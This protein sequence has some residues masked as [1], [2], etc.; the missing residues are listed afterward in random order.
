MIP[1]TFP[2]QLVSGER[3]MTVF[4]ITDTTGLVEWID[5]IPVKEVTA[6]ASLRGTYNAGSA[7]AVAVLASASGLHAGRDYIRVYVDATKSVPWTTNNDGY[8]PVEAVSGV[9]TGGGALIPSYWNYNDKSTV[10][11]IILDDRFIG[12]AAT[13]YGMVRSISS[14]SSGKYYIEVLRNVDFWMIG[15]ASASETLTGRYPGDVGTQSVGLY[16]DQSYENGVGVQVNT[17]VAFTGRVGM[18]INADDREYAFYDGV[19]IHPFRPLPFAGD[20][21]LVGGPGSTGALG[22]GMYLNAGQDAFG[23]TVPS[24]Y[25]AG[26]GTFG[27]RSYTG[28]NSGLSA[29]TYITLSNSNK[30]LTGL[31]AIASTALALHAKTRTMP[32]TVKNYVVE[33][34]VNAPYDGSRYLSAGLVLEAATN[35]DN[36]TD[37]AYTEIIGGAAALSTTFSLNSG[38]APTGGTTAVSSVVGLVMSMD[39]SND[40]IVGQVFIDGVATGGGFVWATV[41][42]TNRLRLYAALTN[43]ASGA[44]AMT[45][46]IDPAEMSHFAAYETSIGTTLHGWSDI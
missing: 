35:I 39:F 37:A 32:L 36:I 45:V 40:W 21:Y 28:F 3:A 10:N 26:F 25:T 5:Y 17:G 20:I 11:A 15:L 8:I 16:R 44:P 23:F 6:G 46:R 19:T 41:G 31:S 22:D 9:F 1:R 43:A 27:S 34:V 14:V 18:L 4:E 33:F 12:Q 13:G 7:F 30:T 2:S 38:A 42:V 29:T 24:G